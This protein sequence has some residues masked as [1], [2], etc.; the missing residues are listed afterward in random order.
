[1]TKHQ[2]QGN[3]HQRKDSRSVKGTNYSFLLYLVNL[4]ELC[5]DVSWFFG[6]LEKFDVIKV[7]TAN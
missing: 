6:P 3:K 5:F 4:K 1:M 7:K 2:R